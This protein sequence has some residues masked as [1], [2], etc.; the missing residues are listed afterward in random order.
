MLHV[1]SERGNIC[2]TCVHFSRVNAVA[3]NL[4]FCLA[5]FFHF[6][7]LWLFYLQENPTLSASLEKF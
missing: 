5:F 3:M 4:V 2:F 1:L 7:I 6:M